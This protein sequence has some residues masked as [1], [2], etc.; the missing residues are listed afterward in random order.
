MITNEALADLMAQSTAGYFAILLD[1][2]W[3]IAGA[4]EVLH[5]CNNTEDI[6]YNG[7]LYFAAGFKYTPPEIKEDYVGSASLS[8][9]TVDQT[10]PDHILRSSSHPS[11]TVRAAYIFATG[12]VETLDGWEFTLSKATWG[13]Q[14][15]SGS[16]IFETALDR[17][18]PKDAFNTQD[19]PGCI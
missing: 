10:I 11:F 5:I 12:A 19:F 3:T 6:L 4:P 14:Q 2:T 17:L 8:I 18:L 1:I 9:C 7:V 13:A 16:I 15:L